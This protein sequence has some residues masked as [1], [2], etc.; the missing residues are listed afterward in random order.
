MYQTVCDGKHK[1]FGP[2]GASRKLELESFSA[3]SEE[4]MRIMAVALAVVETS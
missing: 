3:D 4:D 1:P 2:P